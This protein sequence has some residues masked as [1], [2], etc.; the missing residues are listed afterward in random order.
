MY[1]QK[2]NELSVNSL[3]KSG[4]KGEILTKQGLNQIATD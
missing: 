1:N 2:L 4:K 3:K